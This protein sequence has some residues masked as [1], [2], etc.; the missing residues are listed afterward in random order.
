[1]AQWIELHEAGSDK[2]VSINFDFVEYYQPNEESS[3]R[4]GNTTLCIAE[5]VRYF[6]E[7]Y[8]DIKDAVSGK[9]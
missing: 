7:H 5:S 3:A 1:M 9:E 4:F 6:N 8:Q 2:P